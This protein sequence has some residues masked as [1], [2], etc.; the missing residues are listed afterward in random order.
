MNAYGRNSALYKGHRFPAEIISHCVWVYYR[1]C[2]SLRDVS[3]RML[4][5]GV[6]VSHEA[7]RFWTVKFGAE[8]MVRDPRHHLCL[9]GGVASQL[10]SHR[11]MNNRAENSHQP[12]RQR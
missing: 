12:T 11:R 10:V 1:F 9:R 6:V 8:Y 3:E 7:V 2:L 4:A 5:R